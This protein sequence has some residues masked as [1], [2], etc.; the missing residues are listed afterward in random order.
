MGGS[1]KRNTTID[2]ESRVDNGCFTLFGNV[3]KL[4]ATLAMVRPY[5]NAKWQSCEEV[6]A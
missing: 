5:Q 4:S 6:N 1:S 2:R 3:W